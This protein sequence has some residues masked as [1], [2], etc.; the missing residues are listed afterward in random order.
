MKP[1]RPIRPHR[2]MKVRGFAKRHVP[3]AQAYC[4]HGQSRAFYPPGG[5]EAGNSRAHLHK[6]RGCEH[7]R[8]PFSSSDHELIAAFAA[9][10]Q[11]SQVASFASTHSAITSSSLRPLLSISS[12]SAFCAALSIDMI[13]ISL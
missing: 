11:G 9:S 4:P 12:I 6:R 10:T 3:G 5:L 8:V 7:A 2:A 1:A 13:S